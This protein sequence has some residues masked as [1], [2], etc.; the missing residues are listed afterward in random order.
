MEPVQRILPPRPGFLEGVRELTARH[1]VP[2][3]FDEIV[4]GFRL[5]YGGAQA[6]YGVV[7]DV[8]TLGKVLGGGLSARRHRRARGHHGPLRCRSG[9]TGRAPVA[10]RHP[11]RQPHR[12]ASGSRHPRG[13]AQ[14]RHPRGLSRPASGSCRASRS[15]SPSTGSRRPWSVSPRGS[16]R[17]SRAA[18]SRTTATCGGAMA[19]RTSGST[20]CSSSAGS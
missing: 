10:A 18:R 12:R 11:E 4:T 2:L 17:S 5:A 6:Y 7:P 15:A 19:R 3:V 13:V 9:G 1:D 20:P 16:T 8:C 14:T